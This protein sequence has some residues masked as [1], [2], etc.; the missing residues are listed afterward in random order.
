MD[1]HSVWVSGSTVDLTPAREVELGCGNNTGDAWSVDSPL[2]AN[3]LAL[4]VEGGAPLLL[5]TVDALYVG[6]ALRDAVH[7]A[8]EGLVPIERVIVA[9]SHTHAAPMLDDSK[10]ELGMPDAGHLEKVCAAVSH[11]CQSVLRPESFRLAMASGGKKE[12]DHSINRRLTKK[13][14]WRRPLRF[15]VTGLAPNHRGP[16]DETVTVLAVSLADGTPGPVVW[17]YACHPVKFPK[18]RAASPHYP[19]VVRDKIREGLGAQVPVLFFQGFSGDT[20]PS[21]LAEPK[22][23]EGARQA[24]RRL[25]FGPSWLPMTR[26]RYESWTRSLAA[27]VV[28]ALDDVEPLD[29]K[30]GI[31]AARLAVERTQF[32]TPSGAP[33]TFQAAMLGCDFSLVGLSGE[34]MAV[35]ARWVRK[36]VG[37]KYVMTVGCLEDTAGYMPTRR[38]VREG[39]YEGR[40]FLAPFSLESVSPDIEKNVR[41]A[42]RKVVR[43][44][45]LCA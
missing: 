38:M 39:G 2:E 33:V 14:V 1:D 24:Y 27:V 26:E 15:N 8:V 36:L 43:R 7:R 5:V 37:G 3:L 18:G 42:L 25:R 20:R 23:P 12:A 45:G 19:G 22:F 6:A 17:N 11:A 4:R 35:Y 16:T 13:I 9:A 44:T 41:C 40:G 29:L 34:V 30:G 28:R 31:R 21:V 32:V 10:P